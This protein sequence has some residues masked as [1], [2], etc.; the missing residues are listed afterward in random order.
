MI[1]WDANGL[2]ATAGPVRGVY[3]SFSTDTILVSPAI[4]RQLRELL[5]GIR[6]DVEEFE[7]AAAR[8][9]AGRVDRLLVRPRWSAGTSRYMSPEQRPRA[10]R[11]HGQGQAKR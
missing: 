8:E 7:L 3:Q 5:A 4:A 1:D 10:R 9:E 11:P 2:T 6:R